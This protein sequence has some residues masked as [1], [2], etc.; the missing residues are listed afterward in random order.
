[1]AN[2]QSFT[3]CGEQERCR[4]LTLW[5]VVERS[6][7]T[8]ETGS[9]SQTVQL[10]LSQGVGTPVVVQR[11]APIVP[12]MRKTVAGYLQRQF[13]VA[14][15]SKVFHIL[16]IAPMQTPWTSMLGKSWRTQRLPY[17]YRL[18]DVGFSLPYHFR[19]HS[20]RRLRQRKRFSEKMLT[21]TESPDLL[22]PHRNVLS[23]ISLPFFLVRDCVFVQQVSLWLFSLS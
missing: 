16:V 9:F 3:S 2:V 18:A 5:T 13:S 22:V 7:C 11:Q 1:M 20:T 15:L 4:C 23:F 10:I 17:I 8:T 19:R 12:D 21:S 14:V 6:S